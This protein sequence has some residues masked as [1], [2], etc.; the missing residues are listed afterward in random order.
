MIIFIDLNIKHFFMSPNICILVM[1]LSPDV[2][3][4]LGWFRMLSADTMWEGA[5]G[6]GGGRVELK[7][8]GG[9]DRRTVRLLDQKK[10]T[11]SAAGDMSWV[12]P[13]T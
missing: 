11:D 12:P 9:G 1:E 2:R 10:K 5:C 13:G 3:V 8:G 6:G 7:A 4:C